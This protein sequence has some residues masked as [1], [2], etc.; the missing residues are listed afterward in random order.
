MGKKLISELKNW[1]GE[2]AP[3]IDTFI[4]IL[5]DNANIEEAFKLFM[6]GTF[7]NGSGFE[8]KSLYHFLTTFKNQ[9]QSNETAIDGHSGQSENVHFLGTTGGEVVGTSKLQNLTN[10]TINLSNNTLTGTTSQFNTALSDANFATEAAL[11]LKPTLS[12]NGSVVNRNI[13]VQAAQPTAANI[14]D[15]WIDF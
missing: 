8:P 5:A 4:P 2:V 6:Y 12:Y 11:G 14:G 9:I 15:I 1:E 3:E 13:F 10:K 7:E